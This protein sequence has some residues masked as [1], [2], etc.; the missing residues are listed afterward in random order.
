MMA[1]DGV[2]NMFDIGYPKRTGDKD[3]DLEYLYN[4]VCELSDRLKFEF[5]APTEDA[6]KTQTVEEQ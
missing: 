6:Q 1:A 3:K 2:G 5:K 4:F